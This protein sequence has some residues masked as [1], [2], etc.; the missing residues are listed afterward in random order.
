[1]RL[2]K[3]SAGLVSTKPRVQPPASHKNKCGAAC[4]SLQHWE[5]RAKGSEVQ[6]HL[7]YKEF[8]ASLDYVRLCFCL[9]GGSQSKH[10]GYNVFR[11]FCKW[12]II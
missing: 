5:N 9:G 1:M 12:S 7:G 4:L 2:S 3:E 10:H 11:E 8:G 6:D